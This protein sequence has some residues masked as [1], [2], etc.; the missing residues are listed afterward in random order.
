MKLLNSQKGQSLVEV[1]IALAVF[2]AGV[3]TIGFLVL[4]SNVASR[5]GIERT[6]ATL[7]A[8]EGLEAAR[9]IRDADFDNLTAGSHGIALSGNKW[10]FSGTSDTQNQFTRTVT[11]TNIN[12]D[13]KRVD[14]AV[15]WQ[16]TQARQNS[17]RLTDYLTDWN[18]TQGQA[19]NLSVDIGNAVL[20]GTYKLLQGITIQNTGMGS[21]TIDRMTVWWNNSQLIERIRINNTNVWVW[22]G[23]GTPNGR[24]P[25]GTEL[26]INNVV[27]AQGSGVKNINN[28]S[29]NG[30]MLGATFIIKFIMSDG[31]TKYVLAELGAGPPPDTTPPAVITNLVL[32]GA[33]SN[34]INLVWT[35]PGD[36][37]NT[38]TASSYDVRYST[39]AITEANWSSATQAIGE[40]TPSAAGANESMTVSGLVSDTTYYFAIKTSD[41]VPNTSAISN[42]PSLAT[43]G[44]QQADSLVVDT[45]GAAIDGSDNKKV[46]GITIRNNGGTNI[47]ID[48]MT[49]SW[50]GAPGGTKI[51]G[52]VINGGSVWSGGSNSGVILNIA[53]FSLISGAGSYPINSLT[54]SKNMTGTTLSIIFTMIDGSI[55]TVSSIQP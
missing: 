20:D 5:Q 25:S 15:T 4:D 36:D 7:L 42:V 37:G 13:T 33:T 49:V 14:S 9:S 34:S 26:N 10:I 38:G 28:I 16:F 47:I 48:K 41:E 46:I 3:A 45:T 18:Q 1:L 2:I 6:Q 31:S 23:A 30:S 29:F 12:V 21:I 55:K 39:S 54:F 43:L 24:Q 32:S 27:L 50:T 35:A 51:N 52:I 22:N 8:K 17:V 40:P 11:I 53:D 19:G 44:Q